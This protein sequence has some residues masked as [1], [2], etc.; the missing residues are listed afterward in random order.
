MV[1]PIVISNELKANDKNIP[2]HEN[3]RLYLYATSF[4][5]KECST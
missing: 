4:V 2:I 5:N 1:K 3:Y